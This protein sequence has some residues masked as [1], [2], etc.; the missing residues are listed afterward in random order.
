M[1]Q[2]IESIT[3]TFNEKQCSP[4]LAD[5]LSWT[6]GRKQR[7]KLF[8]SNIFNQHSTLVSD[9]VSTRMIMSTSMTINHDKHQQIESST[10]K[11]SSGKI[12]HPTFEDNSNDYTLIDHQYH[13]PALSSSAS[14]LPLL[15]SMA[16][17]RIR[18]F[19]TNNQNGHFCWS[20]NCSQLTLSTLF[21][22]TLLLILIT[23]G[24]FIIL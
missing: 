3:T 21:S 24:K 6:F 9:S 14:S 7:F 10:I 20:R 22:I 16:L 4:S 8:S 19:H 13:L 17:S 18:L 23:Q 5:W 11:R 12:F 1:K 2:I 15:S